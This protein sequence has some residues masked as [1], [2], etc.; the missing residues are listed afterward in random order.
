M[1]DFC[2]IRTEAQKRHKSKSSCNWYHRLSTPWHILM[3]DIFHLGQQLSLILVLYN[4]VLLMV[5]YSRKSWISLNNLFLLIETPRNLIWQPVEFWLPKETLT[6]FINQTN[7]K[8]W[9][10]RYLFKGYQSWTLCSKLSPFLFKEILSIEN[11]L[12]EIAL[13]I[14]QLLKKLLKTINPE[15]QIS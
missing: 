6:R 15:K 9:K 11:N 5:R 4:P 13:K 8:L 3:V 7:I 12:I 2:R 14:D 1:N 10:K